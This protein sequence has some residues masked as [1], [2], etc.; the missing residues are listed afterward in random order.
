M[1]LNCVIYTKVI[2]SIKDYTDNDILYI[3]INNEV[4]RLSALDIQ[5][6]Y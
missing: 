2:L 4:T 1:I 3:D 5:E 6:L